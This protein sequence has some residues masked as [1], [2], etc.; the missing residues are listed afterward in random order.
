WQSAN[1][2]VVGI[3]AD[4]S[5]PHSQPGNDVV[6]A[7][8]TG[9]W[10]ANESVNFLGS[11]RARLGCAQGHWLVYVTGGF[12]WAGSEF[13][14][15]SAPGADDNIDRSRL[16][17]GWSAGGGIAYAFA[18]PWSLRAEVLYYQFD[19]ARLT[20]P[21]GPSYASRFDLWTARLGL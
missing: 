5:F 18:P 17:G 21:G 19:A 14:R 16:R 10:H 13:T 7:G 3:E 15:L 20:F 12:A 8:V 4:L 6:W 2:I 1:G 9:Q 11:L